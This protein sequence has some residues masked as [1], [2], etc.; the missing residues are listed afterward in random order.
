VRLVSP[1][2]DIRS[3]AAIGDGPVDAVY[4]AVN[5]VTGLTPELSVITVASVTEGIDAQGKVTIRIQDRDGGT[6]TG[7]AADTDIIVASAR[8]YLNAL[9]RMVAVTARNAEVRANP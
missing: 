3:D 7:R 8:A 6:Y 9:N 4:K 1:E 2:G 5:R